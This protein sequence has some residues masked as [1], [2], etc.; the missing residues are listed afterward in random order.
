MAKTVTTA[1]RAPV[2]EAVRYLQ[3]LLRYDTTNPPGNET[4]AAIY[5]ADVLRANGYET[6]VIESSPGRGNVL[7]RYA[8]TGELAPLLLYGH[9][10]VVVAEP[11]R[12]S[13]EPFSGDIADGCLWGRGALDMKSLVVQELMVMLLLQRSGVRLKRDVIFA[14]TADEEVGGTAGMGYLVDHH[15][16]LIRAEYGL[17]EGG[18]TTMYIAGKPFYDVRTAEKGTCRFLVRSTGKP[19]H[20]SVPRPETAV[21]RVCEAVLALQN[22]RLPFHSTPTIA[23]FFRSLCE[24]LGI[25]SDMHELSEHNFERVVQILPPDLAQYLHAITHD[26]AVPTGLH[27]GHKINVI[28][29]EAEASV[30]GRYL[31]GHTADGFMQEIRRILGPAYE[32]EPVDMSVPLEDSP[33]NDLYQTIVSVMSRHAPQATVAPIMLAGATDAKH[34]ARLGTKCLGFGPL[35]VPEGFPLEHMIHGHDER[36]PIDG[37][38]WGVDVLYDVVTEFCRR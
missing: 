15:P 14:A 13:R 4:P 9:T 23:L 28:P 33:G 17:S 18:G 2:D 19:G 31:P 10:D 35:K 11:R 27:A 38:L 25:A 8:G 1:S 12:W 7:A 29:G 30:D 6:T 3:D 34:V 24:S 21:S 20:G 5:L 22:A 37:Y 32:L 16:D 36:I 26:T